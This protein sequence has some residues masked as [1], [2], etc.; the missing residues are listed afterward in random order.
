MSER[1]I[2]TYGTIKD[3]ELHINYRTKFIEALKNFADCR[4]K[5]TVQKL[6]KKRS[7]EQNNYYHAVIVL[8]YQQ[9]VLAEWGESLTH[10]QAHEHLKANCNYEEHVNTN[11]GETIK[12]AKSTTKL[13]TVEMEEYNERCR[14]FI[15]EW[16]GITVPLPN[17]QTKI[18]F[19]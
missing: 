15:F 2:E 4:V 13:T 8:C 17:E 7:V 11:T 1:K 14:R 3:G 10:D 19:K 6:Y 18:D 9:G 5:L 12:L 16:F